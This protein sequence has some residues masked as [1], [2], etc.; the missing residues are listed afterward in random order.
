[1]AFKKNSFR[2]SLLL[3]LSLLFPVCASVDTITPAQSLQEGQTLVSAAGDYEFGFFTPGNSSSR[4]LGI[5]YKKAPQEKKYV[6]VANRENP[7]SNTSGLLVS[8]ANDGNLAVSIPGRKPVFR[9]TNASAAESQTTAT[10]LDSGNLVLRDGRGNWLW[11]SFDF[12]TN[13]L[14]PGMKLGLDRRTGRA[15]TITSW[16]S[17]DDPGIGNYEVRLGT[18]WSPQLFLYKGSQLLWRSGPWNGL[19]FSGIPL[20][21]HQ[22]VVTYHISNDSDGIYYFYNLNNDSVRSRLMV[23]TSGQLQRLAWAEGTGKWKLFWQAPTDQCDK[24]ALCGAFSVC[25]VSSV[26]TCECLQGFRPRQPQE[27]SLRDWAAGCVRRGELGCGKG[28][29]FRKME[30]VKLPDG[31]AARLVRGLSSLRECRDECLKNC[32]CSAYAGAD[33]DKWA[34]NCLIWEGEFTDLKQ[35]TDAAMDLY[36]RSAASEIGE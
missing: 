25:E 11:Q 13:T 34:G 9:I 2:H 4:Y 15:R 10:L 33:I 31:T 23:E 36:V 28:D 35:Y 24:Y 21:N 3:M 12:P 22:S 8:I 27:W 17:E 19:G 16:K 7:L 5:W 30:N 29:G 26:Q 18:D 1:M 20:M 6:W 32:S 14:L